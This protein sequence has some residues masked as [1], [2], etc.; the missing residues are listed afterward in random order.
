MAELGPCYYTRGRR[1]GARPVGD[2]PAG[3]R[4][5]GGSEGGLKVMELVEEVVV[6]GSVIGGR[7]GDM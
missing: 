7:D 1:G 5:R 3:W 4:W 6:D 2:G